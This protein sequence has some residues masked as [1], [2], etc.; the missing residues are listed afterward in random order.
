MSAVAGANPPAAAPASKT[1]AVSDRAKAERK[2]GWM[3]CAPAVIVMLAVT[4]YPIVYAIYLSLQRADLR[5]PDDSEF[6]GLDNY[7][8][9]AR[10]RP[11]VVGR[12]RT[13]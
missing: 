1:P 10:P 13:R 5:F 12:L 6:V 2:L 4:G 11:V 7:G 9:R 3:L 8:T